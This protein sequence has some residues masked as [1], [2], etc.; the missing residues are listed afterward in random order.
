MSQENVEIVRAVLERW[1]NCDFRL[2]P[3]LVDPE[4]ILV[5]SA[6]FPHAGTYSS[7]RELAKYMQGFLEA[8]DRLT[9]TAEEIVEAGDAV[10]ATVRQRGVGITSGIATDLRYFQAW[11]VHGGRII[12]LESYRD[13]REALEAVGLRE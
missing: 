2:D 6:G 7:R 11:S 3:D 4:M 10:V 12:R 5:L 9:I 13:R 8:W 1:G